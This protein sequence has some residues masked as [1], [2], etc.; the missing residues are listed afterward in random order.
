MTPG[1]DTCSPPLAGKYDV[2]CLEKQKWLGEW[3]L[4]YQ[5]VASKKS[6][7]PLGTIENGKRALS[8]LSK[9][10]ILRG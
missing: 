3:D 10:Q 4:F 6:F 8:G 9:N 7:S 1:L 5:N 2:G